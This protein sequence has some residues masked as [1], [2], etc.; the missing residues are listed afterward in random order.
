MHIVS[1]SCSSMEIFIRTD[2]VDLR[3]LKSPKNTKTSVVK[4]RDVDKNKM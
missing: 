4:R 1:S 2:D 3:E